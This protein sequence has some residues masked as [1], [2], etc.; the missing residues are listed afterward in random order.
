ME[1]SRD[2]EPR[3][4]DVEDGKSLQCV[5]LRHGHEQRVYVVTTEA[6]CEEHRSWPMTRGNLARRLG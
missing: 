2:G 1:V 6:D 4:F 3:W 5:L